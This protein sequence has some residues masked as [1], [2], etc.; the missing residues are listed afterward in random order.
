MKRIAWKSEVGE[1]HPLYIQK[2]TVIKPHGVAAVPH[3]KTHHIS[4]TEGAALDTQAHSLAAPEHA[5]KITKQVR[6]LI[7]S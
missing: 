5:A 6:L 4:Q 1:S 3:I 2:E 7:S